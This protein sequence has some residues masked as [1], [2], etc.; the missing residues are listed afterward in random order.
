MLSQREFIWLGSEYIKV[1]VFLWLPDGSFRLKQGCGWAGAEITQRE[2]QKKEG[3]VKVTVFSN[4]LK[5]KLKFN[6]ISLYGD[7]FMRHHFS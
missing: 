4:N 3:T 1:G 2:A 7:F 6:G 5:E